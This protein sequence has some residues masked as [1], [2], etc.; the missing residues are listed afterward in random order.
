M[1]PERWQLIVGYVWF[2]VTC[3]WPL[4]VMLWGVWG[5]K[6]D[7]P[8]EVHTVKYVDGQIVVE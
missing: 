3:T 1:T 4:G 6:N 2:A 7:P 8:T 5:W